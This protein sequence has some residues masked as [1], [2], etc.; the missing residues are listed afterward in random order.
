[1]KKPLVSVVFGGAVAVAVAA[2]SLGATQALASDGT[3]TISPA[4]TDY[5]ATLTSGTTAVLTD[6]TSSLEP[7]ITCTS[8]TVSGETGTSPVTTT[9][10]DLASIT[11]GSFTNCT[12]VLG[13]TWS[14]TLSAGELE[15]DSYSSGVTTGEID[16]I[17]AAETGS[18]AGAS[19]SFDVAGSVPD[20]DAT[21]TNSTGPLK[22]TGADLT[23]SDVTGSGCATA[24]ISDGDDATFTA[25]Y[26][27]TSPSGGITITDP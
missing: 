5:T 18:V 4:S 26:T 17:S 9:P 19:C 20:G 1:M 2:L 12:D 10:A 6:T 13:D 22:V 23:I 15:G 7:S 27:I 21:F 11:S 16:G 25:S 24:G 14:A 8:S 3:W